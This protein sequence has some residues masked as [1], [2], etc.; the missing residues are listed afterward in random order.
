VLNTANNHDREKN[1]LV[2]PSITDIDDYL[3]LYSAA[4]CPLLSTDLFAE[5]FSKPE[6]QT[7]AQFAAD[8]LRMFNAHTSSG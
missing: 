2:G 7:F 6:L 5:G 8:L 1:M 3:T 4:S